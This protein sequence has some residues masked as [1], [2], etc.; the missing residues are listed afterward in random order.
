MSWQ[1]THQSL[2]DL[3][4]EPIP[5]TS[6]SRPAYPRQSSPELLGPE[7][8][9]I[10][11][12]DFAGQASSSLNPSGYPL[13]PSASNISLATPGNTPGAYGQS[14]GY[15]DDAYTDVDHGL[16]DRKRSRKSHRESG[17]LGGF[18]GRMTGGRIGNAPTDQGD[19]NLPLTQTGVAPAGTLPSRVAPQGP[20]KYPEPSSTAGDAAS[21]HSSRSSRWKFSGF[22]FGRA[23]PDPSTLGP[24]IIHLNDSPANA[25]QRF[26]DN[27]VSTAKYNLAT[28][29]PKFLFEQFSKYA[30]LF[31]LFTAIIQQVPN[32]SPT[33]KYTTIGPLAVVLLV[34]AVKE[35]IEDI[36]RHNQDQE[37][38]RSKTEVLQ[39]GEFVTKKW[40]QIRV[41]DIIRV[42]SGEPI[43]AD[44]IVLASSE[45][46]G[47]CYIETANLDGET[48]LKIKQALPETAGII[49][50]GVLGRIQGV[51]KSEQPN[52]HLYTYEG[53]LTIDTGGGEKEFPLSPDQLLLRVNYYLIKLILG[54]TIAKY[55][56]DI[57]HRR[58]HRPRNQINAKRNCNAY[59][60][61][62]SRTYRQHA[63]P[64]P[65]W[66]PHRTLFSL[67]SR[68]DLTKFRIR[69]NVE[70]F[71]LRRCKY[72]R[73]ILSWSPYLLDSIFQSGPYL[74]PSSH[75]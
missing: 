66:H 21:D 64:L 60:T 19:M 48:N 27:R 75:V 73:P 65:L 54:C 7:R 15:F 34:S 51:L 17:G 71:R 33:N 41:G 45:P 24:R 13:T 6:T 22:H 38:N 16:I 56:L 40:Y 2:L 43:P 32:I 55:A 11:Y 35:S 26:C 74:V 72:S 5:S 62:R 3:E 63:S 44:L 8:P 69:I 53:T 70:L 61:N 12:D 23:P 1:P 68:S 67:L 59:Q 39:G 52:N 14:P 18:F 25:A 42:A 28:F 58:L 29:L 46:E 4:D 47:L 49:S 10:S 30:N 31:F 57:R 37:L 20:M 9:S 50:P 36:K